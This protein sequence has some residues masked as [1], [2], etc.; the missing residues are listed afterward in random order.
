M[1][2]TGSL[3]L[4]GLLGLVAII[5]KQEL[6]LIIVGGLFVAEALS[7]LIQVYSF[8]IYGKRIFKMAP[9]VG[10]PLCPNVNTCESAKFPL[11]TIVK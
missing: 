5:I 2:D 7:V 11:L 1:G 10:F 4:G 6:I 8:R 3:F 9:L